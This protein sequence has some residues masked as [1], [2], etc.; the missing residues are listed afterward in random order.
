MA[1]F[2]GLYIIHPSG[3]STSM[4]GSRCPDSVEASRGFLCFFFGAV[5][6]GGAG[7]VEGGASSFALP[8]TATFSPSPR[9][10][11]RLSFFLASPSGSDSV[12]D[13]ESESLSESGPSGLLSSERPIIFN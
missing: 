5:A 7:T 12:D 4:S 9:V 3:S 6:P 11:L 1:G 2:E 8:P 10:A 13:D